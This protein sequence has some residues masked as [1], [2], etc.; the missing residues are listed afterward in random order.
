MGSTRVGIPIV[1]AAVIAAAA[2]AV[3]SSAGI[4]LAWQYEAIGEGSVPPAVLRSAARV[5]L[6]I[7][8][9]GADM[10]APDLAARHPLTYDVHTRRS[11]IS[12]AN[13]HGTFVASLAAGSSGAARLLIIKAGSASGA[14]T[15][16]AESAAIH[17]A[18]D[19]GARIVNISVGG[20]ATSST[21]R[22]AIAYAIA[23]GVL[24]VAPVGNGFGATPMYP[25][26]LL[27]NAGLAVA[28]STSAGGH[29][30][31]SNTGIGVSVTAPGENVL[32]DVPGR[33]RRYESGT[34]FASPLV[35]GAAALVWG[36]NPA[37]SAREVVRILYQTA[38]G[39]GTWTPELGYGVI[40]VAA[41]VARALTT[42]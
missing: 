27:G 36:A 38:S 42:R 5:R 18:V 13:G 7:V 22:A 17:Y 37:L 39:A 4:T 35:A 34:S 29:A 6:A 40:D 24:L 33:P 26:A 28:A 19:H 31:F 41:A 1:S 10:S 16:A 2:L 3:P 14:F 30:A 11:G 21:E 20:A 32:G 9:T 12:D 8:D 25:A 23:H 15:D